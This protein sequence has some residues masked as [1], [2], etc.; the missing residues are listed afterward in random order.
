MKPRCAQCRMPLPTPDASCPRCRAG[1]RGLPLSLRI[2]A[3]V[4]LLVAVLGGGAYFILEYFGSFASAKREDAAA[5]AAAPRPPRKVDA[6]TLPMSDPGPISK[7][8]LLALAFHDY[9]DA[10]GFRP[11]PRMQDLLDERDPSGRP[12]L[13]DP[14]ALLDDHGRP[15]LYEVAEEETRR[16]VRMTTLG[17]DG[18]PGGSGADADRVVLTLPFERR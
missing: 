16:V 17:Q 11:P 7:R 8:D 4:A 6:S 13:D 2:A 14:A 1:L 18:R 10:H 15:W 3:G 5:R 12:F 9:A